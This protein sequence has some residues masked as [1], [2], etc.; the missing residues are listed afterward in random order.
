LIAKAVAR[1]MMGI[2]CQSNISMRILTDQG[3][4]VCREAYHLTLP[5]APD[6]KGYPTIQKLM[7]ALRQGMTPWKMYSKM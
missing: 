1:S 2:M 5:I 7:G 6:R 4:P 3:F